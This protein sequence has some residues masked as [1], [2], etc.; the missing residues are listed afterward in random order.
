MS[1]FVR[2]PGRVTSVL[3]AVCFWLVP[4]SSIWI[5]HRSLFCE[6]H[7]KDGKNPL[8]L[9]SP[10]LHETAKTLEDFSWKFI[11]HGF[12]CIQLLGKSIPLPVESSI[13][14]WKPSHSQSPYRQPLR[15]ITGL[16]NGHTMT[17]LGCGQN[18]WLCIASIHFHGFSTY[19]FHKK[20][21][22][23]WRTFGIYGLCTY[24]Y[25]YIYIN[26]FIYNVYIYPPPK[27]GDPVQLKYFKRHPPL[28]IFHAMCTSACWISDLV[29]C[30]RMQL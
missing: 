1:L 26:M 3:F 10:F 15:A 8:D 17:N 24:I 11:S 29:G 27:G 7:D 2:L 30:S 23:S 22:I 9:S 5:N 28:S 12:N 6:P 14:Q 4:Q 25:I 21:T 13:S 18:P 20:A 19:H 16:W